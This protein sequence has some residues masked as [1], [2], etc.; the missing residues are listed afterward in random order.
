MRMRVQLDLRDGRIDV[1]E[2]RQQAELIM[3]KVDV[4]KNGF[5]RLSTT[6]RA[7]ARRMA[8]GMRRRGSA[9]RG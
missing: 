8:L 4:N 7:T 1:H 6:R 5:V 3:A 9:Q 2:I